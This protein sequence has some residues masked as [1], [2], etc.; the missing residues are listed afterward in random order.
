MVRPAEEKNFKY[1]ILALDVPGMS[2]YISRCTVTMTE[3]A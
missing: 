1:R 3:H 2:A